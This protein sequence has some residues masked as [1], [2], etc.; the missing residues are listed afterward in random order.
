MSHV[1]VKKKWFDLCSRLCD[2][3]VVCEY[4]WD[5]LV[6]AYSSPNRHYHTLEGHIA[7]GLI[8]LEEIRLHRASHNFNAL[9]FAWFFHDSVFDPSAKDNEIQS[10]DFAESIAKKMCVSDEFIQVVRDLI[11]VTHRPIIPQDLDECLIIDIDMENLGWNF[12][13][14]SEQTNLIRQEL[15]DVS[16]SDFSKTTTDLFNSILK[17]DSVFLTPFF[18]EKYELSA[19]KNLYK[20]LTR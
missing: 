20:V 15:P 11:I 9:Q 1:D 12:D 3:D 10:A 7:K 6:S 13:D 19:R 4:S 8:S 18:K 16:D 17:K 5:A 2:S 14:F